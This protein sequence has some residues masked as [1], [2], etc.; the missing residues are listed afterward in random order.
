MTERDR[1]A[2]DPLRTLL[3]AFALQADLLY[4]YLDRIYEEAYIGTGGHG[5]LRGGRHLVR[6]TDDGSLR[7]RF[8]GGHADPPPAGAARSAVYRRDARRVV[9]APEDDD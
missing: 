6:L 5:E 2:D 4:R 3:E 7:I 9:L 1:P 8:E